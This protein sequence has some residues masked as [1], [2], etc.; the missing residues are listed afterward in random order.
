MRPNHTR[1][2]SVNLEWN[3]LGQQPDALGS[4]LVTISESTSV[5]SLDLR[6]TSLSRECAPALGNLL[7]R[8]RSIQHMDLRWNNLGAQSEQYILSGLQSN[9]VIRTVEL[10][11][12]DFSPEC[13]SAAGTSRRGA[14]LKSP[15]LQGI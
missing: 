13:V 15:T 11:G 5:K 8:N 7:A 4:F 10:S 9:P 2:C 14:G 6:N 12:N 1:K 3:S